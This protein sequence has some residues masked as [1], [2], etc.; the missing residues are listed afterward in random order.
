MVRLLHAKATLSE[1]DHDESTIR[2]VLQGA[3]VAGDRS[4]SVA[5]T[6]QEEEASDWRGE[7]RRIGENR[8]EDMISSEVVLLGEFIAVVFDDGEEAGF[9]GELTPFSVALV[10]TSMRLRFW[11]ALSLSPFW[12]L[13]LLLLS[14]T[15]SS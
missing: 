10:S 14:L 9:E 6:A 8:S 11:F 15:S 12:L 7:S 4:D 5:P 1:R 13:V 3:A 2:F